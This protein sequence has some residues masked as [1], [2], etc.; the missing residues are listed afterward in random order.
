MRQRFFLDNK[1]LITIIGCFI[2]AVILSIPIFGHLN[3]SP[4]KMWDESR[5]AINAYEMQ[6]SGNLIVTTHAGEPDMWNTKPPLMIWC[7]ASLM[8]L[9]GVNEIAVRL[10]SAIAALFT[11]GLLVAFSLIYFKNFWFGC[12]ASLVLVTTNGYLNHHVARTGDYDSLLI[13]FMMAY[14]ICLF[15][16]TQTARKK[17]LYLFFLSLMLAV[18]TKGIAGLMFIPGLLIFIACLKEWS[19][20]FKNKH[21]YIGAGIFLM[22]VASYYLFREYYNPGYLLT[23]WNNELGGRYLKT[24]EGHNH[25]FDFYYKLLKEKQAYVWFYIAIIGSIIGLCSID[26]KTRK[27]TLFSL[28]LF[29]SYFL[30]ISSGQTKLAWYSAP[31]FPLIALLSAIIFHFI[32]VKLQENQWIHK[33][34]KYYIPILI[35]MIAFICPYQNTLE[36]VQSPK[37]WMHAMKIS[38]K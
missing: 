5:L 16:Y 24:I 28:I 33:N 27:L 19:I 35:L 21:F 13:F 38:M 12:I 10:P 4:I 3:K 37:K 25:P 30:V 18:L 22:G 15:L 14:S 7:Q 20:F 8:K 32:F 2:L 23:V 36:R 6:K 31:F 29:F 34:F 17:Y 9:I 11:C 26:K 1:R